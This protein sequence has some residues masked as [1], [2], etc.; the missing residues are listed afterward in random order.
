MKLIEMLI[1]NGD[2]TTVICGYVAFLFAA[3]SIYIVNI[4][5]RK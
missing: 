1:E 4:N 2:I 5:F 3:A